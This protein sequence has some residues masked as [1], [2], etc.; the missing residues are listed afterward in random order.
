MGVSKP[1]FQAVKQGSV[2]K[3]I[4]R[5]TEKV[6]LEKNDQFNQVLKIALKTVWGRACLKS[7]RKEIETC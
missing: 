2:C 4:P 1:C 6:S 7:T 5:E 3:Y